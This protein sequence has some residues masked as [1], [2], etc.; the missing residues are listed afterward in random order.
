MLCVDSCTAARSRSSAAIVPFMSMPSPRAIPYDLPRKHETRKRNIFFVL[1]GFRGG[2]GF[3]RSAWYGSVVTPARFVA[4]PRPAA[5]VVV[6]R[7]AAAGPEVFLVRRHQ[8]TAF[9]GG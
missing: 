6:M 1:S 5:T 2:L 4:N 7:D 3:V 8:D 9:M